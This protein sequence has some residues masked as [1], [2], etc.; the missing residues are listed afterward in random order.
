MIRR[1]PISTRTDTLFPYTTL[2]RS[3]TGIKFLAGGDVA[4][5]WTVEDAQ[6]Y[7]HD[8]HPVLARTVPEMWERLTRYTQFHGHKVSGL[9]LGNWLAVARFVPMCSDMGLETQQSFIDAYTS[10]PYLRIIRPAEE[11]FPRQGE[12]SAEHT[13]DIQSLM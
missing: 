7:W 5:G 8:K 3:G 13:S 1:P 9:E 11:K 10:E 12:R 4:E 2:F 6:R